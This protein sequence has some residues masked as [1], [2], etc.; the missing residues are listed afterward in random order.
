M[1]S[2][3]S[4]QDLASVLEP[5]RAQAETRIKQELFG[6]LNLGKKFLYDSIMPLH[7]NITADSQECCLE[8]LQG[9]NIELHHASLPSPDVTVKGDF[10]TLRNVLVERSSSAFEEAERNGKISVAGRTWKGQQ[11]MEKVRELLGSNPQ[12]TPQ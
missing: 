3:I 1:E 11:A 12:Q 7:V 4:A 5:L 9:G 6:P 2:S 10:E 8:F